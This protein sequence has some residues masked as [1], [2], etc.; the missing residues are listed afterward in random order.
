MIKTDA[1]STRTGW[2]RWL[3]IGVMAVVL[4]DLLLIGGQIVVYQ[5]LLA[6]R[7][8]LTYVLE[9]VALL[10][11]Y[12]AATLWITGSANAAR[13]IALRE[14]TLIGLIGGILFIINLASETFL[15]LATPASLF[16]TA[17][18]FLGTFALW[19][20]A[21]YRSGRRT[22]SVPLGI[23]AAIWSAMCTILLTI[24]FGFILAYI[25]LP[26]LQQ[27]LANSP[28]YARSGWHDLHAF[29]IANQFDAAFSHLLVA[30]IIAAF[31]GALGSLIGAARSGQHAQH[32]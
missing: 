19:G 11:A 9:P 6:Q 5:P 24:T 1:I 2:L 15:D 16:T 10:L 26:R 23:L 17:P 32:A 12:T 7:N 27:N 13:R 28:E 30:V 20:V 31:L 3:R 21:G 18:F 14:G 22:G 25:A 4:L 29:A 8:A